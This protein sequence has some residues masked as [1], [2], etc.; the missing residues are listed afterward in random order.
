M[1]ILKYRLPF[2]VATSSV[3]KAT[4]AHDISK[5]EYEKHS[6]VITKNGVVVVTELCWDHNNG[7]DEFSYFNT[8]INGIS[9]SA[10]L[11]EAR[12]SERQLRWLA[13][14]F[15]NNII[16]KKAVFK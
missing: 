3:Y 9:Y 2:R 7:V 10:F 5:Y 14:N 11:D 13:T 16:N 8:T 6:A 12:L 4:Y 1:K 15:I